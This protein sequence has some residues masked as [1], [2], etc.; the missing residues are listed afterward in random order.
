VWE[1]PPRN[2]QLTLSKHAVPLRA[3][4]SF[5]ALSFPNQYGKCSKDKKSYWEICGKRNETIA[6]AHNSTEKNPGVK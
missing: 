1:N 5:A 3:K 2:S 6:S 4:S